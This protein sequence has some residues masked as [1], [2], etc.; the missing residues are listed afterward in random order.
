MMSAATRHSAEPRVR[1]QELCASDRM[2]VQSSTDRSRPQIRSSARGR[3]PACEPVDML[4]PFE[5]AEVRTRADLLAAGMSGR[6]ITDA[7]R[8]GAIKRVRRDRYVVAGASD[9]LVKAVRVGGRLGCVSALAA[10][11]VWTH[12]PGRVHVQLDRE[13]SRLRSPLDRG[14]P[15]SRANRGPCVLHWRDLVEPGS[16]GLASVGIVDAMIEAVVCQ[17]PW[18][19]VA[20]LDDA[21]HRGLLSAAQLDAVFFHLP[22]RFQ[23]LRPLLDARSQSGLESVFR[24]LLRSAGHDFEIQVP[25]RGVGRVDFVVAG[26]LVIETDGLGFHG[27]AE[28]GRD[29]DRDLA[30]AAR[31]YIVMRLSYRQVMYEQA[32]V[33]RALAIAVANARTL[34]A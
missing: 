26:R 14:E 34:A 33:L 13:A 27:E 28:R 11:G 23:Y 22:P 30:L 25:I 31:G 32:K 19:S 9:P 6:A 17:H 2:P 24:M 18:Y 10:A 8:S 16:A 29:Y 3:R 20:A 15:L 4:G 5:D 21:L 12:A 1:L 7:V